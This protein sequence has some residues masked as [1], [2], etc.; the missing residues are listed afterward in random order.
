M[1][2][3]IINE[4]EYNRLLIDYNKQIGTLRKKR[5]KFY[6]DNP[7][8]PYKTMYLNVIAPPQKLTIIHV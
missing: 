7:N 3:E 2:K 8:F 6:K 4:K 1:Y 5:K